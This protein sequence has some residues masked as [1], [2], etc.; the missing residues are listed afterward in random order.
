MFVCPAVH[1]LSRILLRS[2]STHEPS[3]PP[4]R[5]I[6]FHL[7][8]TSDEK[9]VALS[10]SLAITNVFRLKNADSL[11]G[12]QELTAQTVAGLSGQ[13]LFAVPGEWCSRR[14]SVHW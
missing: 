9:S 13:D 12:R 7:F 5:V 1:R 8:K 2:S 10:S 14:L 3:D 4:L 11:A 6:W